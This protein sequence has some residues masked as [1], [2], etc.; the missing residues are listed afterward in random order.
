MSN[1]NSSTNMFRVFARDIGQEYEEHHSSQ[2]LQ[3]L[4]GRDDGE[5][6]VVHQEDRQACIY[7]PET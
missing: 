1:K 4:P 3:L 7:C 6:K 2:A 5:S